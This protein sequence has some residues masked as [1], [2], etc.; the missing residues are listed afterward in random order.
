MHIL[1]ICHIFVPT[2]RDKDMTRTLSNGY[3]YEIAQNFFG[4]YNMYYKDSRMP[5]F[6]RSTKS[7][8]S[9]QEAEEWF[10][11]MEADM[12]AAKN[13]PKEVYTMPA[14]AYYSITG[15]Y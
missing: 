5:E 7:F 1:N 8:K 11:K 15:Y 6:K 14:N 3:T 2:K 4:G 10:E 12:L 9:I 13:A